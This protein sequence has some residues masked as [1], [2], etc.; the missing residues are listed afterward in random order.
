MASN[1][2]PP[3]TLP[4]PGRHWLVSFIF[5]L[6]IFGGGFLVGGA[7]T[8]GVIH[9]HMMDSQRHPEKMPERITKHLKRRLRLSDTQAQSVQQIL[10]KHQ[11]NL[12]NIFQEVKPRIDA[13]FEE[14]RKDVDSVLNPDQAKKWDERFKYFHDK[15]T[16]PILKAPAPAPEPKTP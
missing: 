1:G 16:P 10:E 4:K 11:R 13:E 7:A 6:L 3:A 8:I 15:W 9:R 12:S 5:A 2:Q 14:T